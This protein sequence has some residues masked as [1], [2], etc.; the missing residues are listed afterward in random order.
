MQFICHQVY[1]H[2]YTKSILLIYTWHYLPYTYSL[3]GVYLSLKGTVYANKSVISITEIGKTDTSSATPPQNT[4][5]GLQCISDKLPCCRFNPN[6]VG[7]WFFSDGTVVPERG[8]TLYRNRGQNDGTVNLNRAN[9]N[10]MSPTGLFCCVVPDATGVMQRICANVCE[11]AVSSCNL[12]LFPLFQLW[13]PLSRSV[14]V[15]QLQLQDRTTPSLVMSPE[16]VSPPTSGG[17]MVMCC[18]K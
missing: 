18:L 13:P 6:R 3:T 16:L 10:V 12:T 9:I 2:T 4:N 5:N 8:S 15:E 17:K 7:E 14:M 11:L 1:M